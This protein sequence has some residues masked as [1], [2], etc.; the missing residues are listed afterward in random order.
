MHSVCISPITAIVNENL[1]HLSFVFVQNRGNSEILNK[2]LLGLSLV[3]N[4][5]SIM[6]LKNMFLALSTISLQNLLHVK[7]LE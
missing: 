1:N 2:N 3:S 7:R 5:R 4:L 6:V